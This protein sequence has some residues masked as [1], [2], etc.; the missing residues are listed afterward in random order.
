[1]MMMKIAAN[2]LKCILQVV[3]IL[4]ALWPLVFTKASEIG[5]IKSP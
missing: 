2:F 1:M 3:S 5:I 4:H